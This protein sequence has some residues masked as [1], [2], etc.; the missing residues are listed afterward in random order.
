MKTLKLDTAE[1]FEPVISYLIRCVRDFNQTN[2]TKQA[3]AWLFVH[4]FD[5]GSSF[6]LGI[7][8]A[9]T[10]IASLLQ[11]HEIWDFHYDGDMNLADDCELTGIYDWDRRWYDVFFKDEQADPLVHDIEVLSYQDITLIPKA[12][13][14]CDIMGVTLNQIEQKEPENTFN[15]LI[16]QDILK[17]ILKRHPNEI[18][19]FIL[20]NHDSCLTP[21]WIGH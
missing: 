18:Q 9:C 3:I 5:E 19:G 1:V 10:D 6:E 4:G 2:N 15:R 12:H 11:D 21:I 16:Y 8:P 7:L 20:E 13:A 14:K 17:E